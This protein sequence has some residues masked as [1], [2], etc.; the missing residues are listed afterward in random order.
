L[1]QR[2]LKGL[3]YSL[4]RIKQKQ[5]QLP[6]MRRRRRRKRRKKKSQT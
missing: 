3:V 6:K 2:S 4:P 1:T 5:P